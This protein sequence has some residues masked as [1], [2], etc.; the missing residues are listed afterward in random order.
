MHFCGLPVMFLLHWFPV[1]VNLCNNTHPYEEFLRRGALPQP[2]GKI[3]MVEDIITAKFPLEDVNDLAGKFPVYIN[4]TTRLYSKLNTTLQHVLTTHGST[5]TSLTFHLLY[6]VYMAHY[7][8]SNLE[9]NMPWST[10]L[11]HS[12]L[13]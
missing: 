12:Q 11:C 5:L 7:S 13:Q 8:L 1:L 9:T 6:T 2:Q 4:F 3:L 10:V